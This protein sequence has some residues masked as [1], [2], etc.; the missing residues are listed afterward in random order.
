MDMSHV[1]LRDSAQRP[2]VPVE[3]AEVDT[4]ECIAG[5]TVASSELICKKMC[6][7]GIGTHVCGGRGSA[8]FLKD[9]DP[10]RDVIAER[11]ANSGRIRLRNY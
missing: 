8:V 6:N 11:T 1:R 5:T 10:N 3:I 4:S 2:S 7:A 9:H